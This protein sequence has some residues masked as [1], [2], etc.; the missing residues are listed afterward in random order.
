MKCLICGQETKGSVGK[1]GIK[2]SCLCQTCKDDEDRILEQKLVG[3]ARILNTV[4]KGVAYEE[5]NPASR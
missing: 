3:L 1:A 5:R 2:W 4:N